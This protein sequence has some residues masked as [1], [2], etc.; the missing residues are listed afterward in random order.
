MAETCTIVRRIVVEGDVQGVGYREFTRRAALRLG[1]S[2]WVRNRSDGAVE[3]LISRPARRCRGAGRRDAQRAAICGGRQPE[4]DRARRDWMAAT[5]ERSSS[6]R[7]R[8]AGARRE[9]PLSRVAAACPAWDAS[10]A[11][12]SGPPAEVG[13]FA[14][15][16][17]AGNDSSS[18]SSSFSSAFVRRSARRR[19][20]R[21]FHLWV[22]AERESAA[23][24]PAP[25]ILYRS[26]PRP[27]GEP[28]R[29]LPGLSAIHGLNRRAGSAPAP[30]RR[31]AT[32]SR[33]R[34][35]RGDGAGRRAGCCAAHS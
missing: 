7:R 23:R 2:G 18:S 3:A 25:S 17:L 20:A 8:S 27:R 31:P 10:S 15:G 19:L 22:S 24:I 6:G 5:T 26:A 9:P 32:I 16:S 1:V 21:L 4:R 12:A 11:A 28:S 30:I 34:P 29:A 13:V 33:R 35:P 14:G